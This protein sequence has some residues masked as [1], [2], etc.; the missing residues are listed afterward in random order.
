M[1]TPLSGC[2]HSSCTPPVASPDD[3]ET[4]LELSKQLRKMCAANKVPEDSVEEALLSW[5]EEHGAERV[6]RI[7]NGVRECLTS[8]PNIIPRTTLYRA[9]D[10]PSFHPLHTHTLS[11]SLSL[12]IYLSIYLSLSLSLSLARTPPLHAFAP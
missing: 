6:A 12:S 7:V 8:A 3:D 2:G 9:R 11:V 4:T 10:S 1:S 5:V